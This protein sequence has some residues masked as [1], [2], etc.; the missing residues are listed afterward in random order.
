ML[1][2]SIWI[3]KFPV[4]SAKKGTEWILFPDICKQKWWRIIINLAAHILFRYLSSVFFNK[5]GGESEVS[6]QIRDQIKQ[7]IST[8]VELPTT[9]FK[10]TLFT[11]MYMQSSSSLQYPFRPLM[12]L[13]LLM[14]TALLASTLLQ[15]FLA[16]MASQT[17]FHCRTSIFNIEIRSSQNR[18][19]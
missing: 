17:R 7:M 19:A 3:W 13:C 1:T 18:P 14:P 12:C 10:S 11:E 8:T 4:V 6:W 5:K 9:C 16:I 15:T 2:Y